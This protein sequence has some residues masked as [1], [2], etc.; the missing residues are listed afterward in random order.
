MNIVSESFDNA[1]STFRPPGHRVRSACRVS[2]QA[3]YYGSW[4][5]LLRWLAGR[6]ALSKPRIGSAVNY[7]LGAPGQ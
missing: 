3:R 2:L 1:L 4:G 6:H 5:R 7:R